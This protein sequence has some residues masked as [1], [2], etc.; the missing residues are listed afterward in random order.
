MG[1]KCF[2]SNHRVSSGSGS[3]PHNITFTKTSALQKVAE[4]VALWS[5]VASLPLSV[6][7]YTAEL[8]AYCHSHVPAGARVNC[9]K[10]S[11]QQGCAHGA[12][13]LLSLVSVCGGWVESARVLACRATSP[14]AQYRKTARGHSKGCRSGLRATGT[15]DQAS[16]ATY[17]NKFL[18][19]CRGTV[20]HGFSCAWYP[21]TSF[22]QACSVL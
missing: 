8:P 18:N 12:R 21:L 11:V 15:M 19:E 4:L 22:V 5:S 1:C 2:S 13:C 20:L 10:G 7:V 14:T 6:E 3:L 16:F 17:A 9:V